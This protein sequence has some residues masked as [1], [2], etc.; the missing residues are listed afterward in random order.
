MAPI[1]MDSFYDK[2]CKKGNYSD[3]TD[4]PEAADYD[5]ANKLFLQG[6]ASLR[7]GDTK[8]NT[9]N[10]LHAFVLNSRGANMIWHFPRGTSHVKKK[11]ILDFNTLKELERTNSRAAFCPNKKLHALVLVIMMGQLAMGNT[12]N[13]SWI[14]AT[15]TNIEAVF[16][17]L[18]ACPH[19]DG[20]DGMMGRCLSSKVL[21]CMRR[22]LHMAMGN[23]KKAV[24]DLT[25]ALKIDKSYTLARIHRVKIWAYNNLKCT[26]DVHREYKRIVAELHEDDPENENSYT[27]LALGTLADPSLGSTEDA[28]M[29]Y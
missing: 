3:K 2:C 22:S 27:V 4:N 23:V 20:W 26:K 14:T 24:E 17:V 13:Q 29:Y 5:K 6:F 18:K 15:I 25:N 9:E 16:G 19:I 21:L 11:V 12:N 7:E 1:P 10:M 8:K 28:K